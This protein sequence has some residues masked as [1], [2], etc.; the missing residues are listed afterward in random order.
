MDTDGPARLSYEDSCKL[1]QRLGYL[2]DGATPPIPDHR[3]QSA[4]KGHLESAFIARVSAKMIW[5]T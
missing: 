2:E 1:L 5:E 3:P 4:T